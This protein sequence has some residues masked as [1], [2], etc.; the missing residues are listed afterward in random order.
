M[1][2]AYCRGARDR[3]LPGQPLARTSLS[4]DPVAR[5]LRTGE[6][7][8]LPR[9][10]VRD[11]GRRRESLRPSPQAAPHAGGEKGPR[12]V[13][14]IPLIATCGLKRK[15]RGRSTLLP[16]LTS[17]SLFYAPAAPF[18][19]CRLRLSSERRLSILGSASTMG[20]VP[21]VSP[22][23]PESSKASRF[24]IRLPP[25]LPSELIWIFGTT[26]EPDFSIA[27]AKRPITCWMSWNCGPP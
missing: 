15:R 3:R 18:P 12:R 24:S 5:P 25:P 16:R 14:E 22:S 20:R 1:A 8:V 21:R 27:S 11:P 2:D 6:G 4:H 13:P 10:P 23:L 7:R 17:R 26:S 19:P 9:R